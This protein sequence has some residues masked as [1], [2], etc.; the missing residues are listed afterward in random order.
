M[1]KTTAARRGIV[2]GYPSD[3]FLDELIRN[4]RSQPLAREVMRYISSI[5][6]ARRGPCRKQRSCPSR[7]WA[8]PS[9]CTARTRRA[10]PSTGYWPFDIIPRMIRASSEW[11][12]GR[13]KAC[14][15][16]VHGP[17]PVHRRSLP[18]AEGGQGRACSPPTILASSKQL[19]AS[20]APASARPSNVWAHICGIRPGARR[21]RH[22]LRAGRQPAGAFRRVL[23]AGEP[24]R[25]PSACSPSCSTAYAPCCR[26]TT[27]PDQL[28]DTLAALSPRPGDYARL[29]WC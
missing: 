26:W 12:P 17:Q 19:S 10:T 13:R 3:G 23:H 29:W 7:R 21:R 16:R 18:R 4:G 25:S 14:K 9:P 6:G 1:P 5:G 2:A 27:I 22:H 15:Q 11:E 28:Y 8:S 20:S 24:R